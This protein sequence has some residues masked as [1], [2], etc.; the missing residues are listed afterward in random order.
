[1]QH[2]LDAAEYID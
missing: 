2:K 1:M